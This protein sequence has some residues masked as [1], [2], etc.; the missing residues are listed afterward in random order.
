MV[1]RK[2]PDRTY[3]FSFSYSLKTYFQVTNFETIIMMST[4]DGLDL[5]NRYNLNIS[6]LVRKILII[7]NSQ[8]DHLIILIDTFFSIRAYTTDIW[9][10]VK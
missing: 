4:G 10:T 1:Q 6:I 3:F 8:F 9:H 5:L 2:Y 7:L